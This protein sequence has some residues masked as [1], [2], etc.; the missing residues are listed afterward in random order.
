MCGLLCVIRWKQRGITDWN[1]ISG[2]DKFKK[3]LRPGHEARVWP[4]CLTKVFGPVGTYKHLQTIPNPFPISPIIPSAYEIIGSTRG[5]K[6]RSL[7]VEVV[8][9]KHWKNLEES[10]SWAN[11]VSLMP[12]SNVWHGLWKDCSW[13]K[14][15]ILSIKM[16]K[17]QAIWNAEGL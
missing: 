6:G 5:S 13:I 12:S 11:R 16:I 1:H 9:L 8:R 3:C 2:V 7:E 14:A 15:A 17:M 10:Y 4:S